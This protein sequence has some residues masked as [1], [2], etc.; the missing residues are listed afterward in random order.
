MNDSHPMRVI[1]RL[2]D[3][4]QKRK[5]SFPVK[6][7]FMPA[8]CQKPLPKRPAVRVRH[9]EKVAEIRIPK[10]SVK[11]ADVRVAKRSS[12]VKNAADFVQS[13]GVS[14]KFAR[15]DL[16][17]DAAGHFT[18]GQF[19]REPSLTHPAF[20]DLPAKTKISV[21]AK[22]AARTKFRKLLRIVVDFL[23]TQCTQR[24]LDRLRFQ[25]AGRIFSIP[26]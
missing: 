10:P 14:L 8:L 11:R 16:Q 7:V 2:G 21:L 12:Q 3:R 13:T 19:L 23:R 20:A 6:S 4:T 26:F 18:A 25:S 1:Q 15:E 17:N 9:D 22:E 24:I 5:D